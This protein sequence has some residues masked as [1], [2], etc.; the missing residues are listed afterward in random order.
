[1][2]EGSGEPRR[3]K[4]EAEPNSPVGGMP[5]DD[6]D[7]IEADSNT[8]PN[9]T[10]TEHPAHQT[11]SPHLPT[12]PPP[13]YPPTFT[14]GGSSS[15]PAY[16]MGGAVAPQTPTIQETMHHM[17]QMQQQMMQT[18]LWNSP[19]A[20]QPPYAPGVWQGDSGYEGTSIQEEA[21]R[22][23]PAPTP[24]P[25]PPP[26]PP[27]RPPQMPSGPGAHQDGAPPSYGTPP[28]QA[29]SQST[30][31]AA[32]NPYTQAGGQSK[33]PGNPWLGYPLTTPNWSMGKGQPYPDGPPMPYK[34]KGF[35]AMQPYPTPK[36]DPVP[37]W[38][39]DN[40]GAK[41]RDYLEELQF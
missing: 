13:T 29:P 27:E 30:A 25:A 39:F 23:G 37:T 28:Q 36:E 40:P 5:T 6:D 41:L 10:G 16:G 1:M 8:L 34:G 21:P 14:Q 2:P 15:Q 7:F 33:A 3:R 4:A 17:M 31:G 19:Y 22:P 9:G 11:P 18:M 20:W 35:A 24:K 12:S 26:P 32:S 38:D